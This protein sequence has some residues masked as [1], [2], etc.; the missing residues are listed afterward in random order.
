MNGKA[1]I[2]MVAKDKYTGEF[3]M[4]QS[5]ELSTDLPSKNLG[6]IWGEFMRELRHQGN[7]PVNVKIK[8]TFS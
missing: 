2:K 4:K 7:D 8:I 6:E 3:L 5:N 1:K